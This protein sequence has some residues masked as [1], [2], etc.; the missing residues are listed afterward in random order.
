MSLRHTVSAKLPR[1]PT[2][3]GD[4]LEQV[5]EKLTRYTRDAN[6]AM[7]AISDDMYH[8][9]K[10]GQVNFQVYASA[11]TSAN[12]DIGQIGLHFSGLSAYLFTR[13]SGSMYFVKLTKV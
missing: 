11:P 9:Q 12:M 7:R 10:I 3:K 13:M 1:L 8:D 2:F 6:R 4:T 5:Q